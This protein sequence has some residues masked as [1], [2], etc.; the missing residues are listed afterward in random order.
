MAA[1][2]PVADFYGE[3]EVAPLCA[4]L[5][6]TFVITS[7]ATTHEA[8]LLRD[9][10]FAKLERRV[11]I[12][13]IAGAAVGVGVGI[14]TH[15]AWALI[16]QQLTQ[17]FVSSTLLWIASPWRPRV[18]FSRRSARSLG[19][20]SAYLVGHR[21]LYYLHRNA[22]NILIGRF[23]GAAALGAYT[24]AYNIMLVPM[25]RISGPVQKV[26]GPSFARLQDE[27]ERIAAAWVR[28]VR[29]IAMIAVPAMFG[30][31]VVAP[32]FVPVVLGDR[33]EPAV[34]LIQILAWVG[35]LQALQSINTDILQALGRASTIFRFTVLFSGAHIIA[36]AIGLQW[37]VIGVAAAYAISSTLVE[38]IYTWLTA[39]ALGVSA[40]R[41][42]A[43]VRGVFEAA[44]L[45]AACMFVLRLAL[46]ALELP[47]WLRLASLVAAGIACFAAASAWRAPEGW[48]EVRA[49][50]GDL[51]VA[52]RIRLAGRVRPTAVQGA[53]SA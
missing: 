2:G 13:T 45:M 12:S 15:D 9:M 19:S 5:A 31:I 23:I 35:V 32:D 1:S 8:L 6:A 30:L 49:I 24:L 37:G 27:R 39:R 46:V 16:A 7:L 41:V 3:P 28:V 42:V 53:D 17:A 14:K 11:M 18:R 43:G 25:S 34:P 48:S 47:A 29:L 52:R 40:W 36:F 50:L 22:D 10:Q 44:V 51:K 38:P 20:F 33:W 26:L 4:A 21:L